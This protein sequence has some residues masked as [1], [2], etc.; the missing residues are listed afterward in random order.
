MPRDL[1]TRKPVNRLTRADFTAFPIWEYAEDEEG[2]ERQDETYVRPVDSPVVPRAGY[3][4]VAAEFTAPNGRKY[5]GFVTV[6]TLDIAPDVCQGVIFH[7]RA[8][9]FVSNPEAFGFQESRKQ[10]LAALKVREDEVFPLSFR[11]NA[12]IAGHTSPFAGVLP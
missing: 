10:L 3:T 4:H 11:L 1:S 7:G 9:L 8:S 5:S 6:S 2:V 12:P